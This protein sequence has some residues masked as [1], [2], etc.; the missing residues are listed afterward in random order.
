VKVTESSDGLLQS[1]RNMVCEEQNV[2][3]EWG[4]GRVAASTIC[5]QR[6]LLMVM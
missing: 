4:G 1:F 5:S 6:I 2:C 3:M